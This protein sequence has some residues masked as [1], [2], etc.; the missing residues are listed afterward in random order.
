MLEAETF[1]EPRGAEWDDSGDSPARLISYYWGL[2]RKYYW[3]VLI[4][5]IV[6]VTAGYFWTKQQPRLF[7]TSSKII[8]HQ[9]N[10][11]V[12]GKKIERVDLID[13]G[14]R[15]QFEQFWNTQKEVLDSRWFAERIV[16]RLDLLSDES[17]V[18]ATRAGEAIPPEERMRSAVGRIQGMTSVELQRESRVA[19]V[20]AT[21][22]DPQLA[23]DVAN[24][25][26]TSYIEYTK[27]FQS[28][29]LDQIVNWFDQYV[30]TKRAEL[31][32][33]QANL[34][35]FKRDKNI[36]SI[37]YEERQNLTAANM[38][39]V[40]SELNQVENELSKERALKE[41]LREM[42][43]LGESPVDVARFAGAETLTGLL[44]KQRELNTQLADIQTIFGP[45]HERVRAIND[46]LTIV[47]EAIQE[48]VGRALSD[49]NNR[50]EFLQRQR[51]SLQ[52]RLNQLREEAFQLNEM[53]LTYNQMKDR[54]ESL[55]QLYDTV[56]KRSE[57][58]DVNS[59]F[60]SNSIQVLED[61]EKPRAPFSPNLPYNLGIALLVGLALGGGVIFLIAALDNTVKAEEDVTRYTTA[62][63]LGMLPEVDAAT[64]KSLMGSVENPLDTITHEAPKSSFA[65]GIK[66]LRT[67][68]M[69]MAA[70]QPPKLLL[71]TSPGPGEGKTLISTNMAIAMAQSGLKTILVDNDLRR[72]R[73]HKALGIDRPDGLSDVI[74]G[75]LSLDDAVSETKIPN[76]YALPAGHIPPNPTE[77]MHTKSFER[78][79][80]EL[81]QKFDRVI[82]DSPP[83][84]AVADAL[85][86]SRSVDAVM[87]VLKYG[88]TRKEMLKR[89]V[90]Q[91]EAIGAPLMGIVLNDIKK[92]AAGYGYAYYY[93]RYSYE[94]KPSSR[95]KLAS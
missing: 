23:Q 90:D 66:T 88:Q 84:G 11:N 32:E 83:V 19:L 4:T 16:N 71:V 28:G 91:L 82:L 10:A 7:K 60:E 89:T 67:N 62:P 2:V 54:A 13:P 77:L 12:F 31:N 94:E 72:P 42:R 52:G 50:V 14:G 87:L 51:T 79:I 53:G 40:N 41:Q 8:F 38:E 43:D 64:L 35:K 80:E 49:V 58:L 65:E 26:S 78:V 55:R 69:F 39:A 86:L 63:V 30:G 9:N 45:K 74:A 76:L 24:T 33:A 17:F 57:E 5:S 56:L 36:L 25:Y 18:P 59:M 75:D 1:N 92:D 61:A 29:G 15:W 3:I 22:S 37:S 34:H 81:S 73:V 27:E 95:D 93:Y 68:L 6:A 44:G 46:Q 47:E 20:T 85:I 48:E 70:D 21:S